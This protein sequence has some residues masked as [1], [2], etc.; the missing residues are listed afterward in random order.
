MEKKIIPQEIREAY[1]AE[2][3]GHSIN[4][5]SFTFEGFHEG[6]EKRLNT[7]KYSPL[8]ERVWENLSKQCDWHF[9]SVSIDRD[10]L[11]KALEGLLL[12]DDKYCDSRRVR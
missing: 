9:E 1:E 12:C 2:L 7:P 6:A 5:P 3:V 8:V 11:A 10:V 4:H